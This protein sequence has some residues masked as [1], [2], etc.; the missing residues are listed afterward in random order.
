MR[1]CRWKRL[2]ILYALLLFFSFEFF[3]ATEDG[4]LGYLREKLRK[5]TIP[6][7]MSS[8]LEGEIMKSIPA[9]SS[10]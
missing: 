8:T 5:D 6:N 7:M 4:V 3:R 1:I 10:E 2:R 9:I